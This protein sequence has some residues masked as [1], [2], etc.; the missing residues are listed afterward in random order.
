MA[1]LRSHWMKQMKARIKEWRKYPARWHRLAALYYHIYLRQETPVFVYTMAK[2]GS[3]AVRVALI[4]VYGT[5]RVYPVHSLEPHNSCML[6]PRSPHQPTPLLRREYRKQHLSG[7]RGRFLFEHSKQRKIITLVR[8][9]IAR[10]ISLFFHGFERY[11]G[12][13][14]SQANRLSI[15]ELTRLFLSQM[16]HGVALHWFDTELKAVTGI[17]VYQHPFDHAAGYSIIRQPPT[18]L[19]I[20]KTDLEDCQKEQAIRAFVGLPHYQL[21]RANVTQ[22][23]VGSIYP[24]F[25][26]QVE[27]PSWYIE[28]MYRSPFVRHFFSSQEVAQFYA[29][30]HRNKPA[31]AAAPHR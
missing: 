31:S 29:R 26:Q 20:L 16:R 1:F 12:V 11:T 13:P 8:D 30:W 9:P 5:G 14:L 10:N 3:L 7:T 21:A 15:A 4:D 28:S 18:E 6:L 24:E 23:R 2:V 25:V 27:L 22:E 17:D 19:L